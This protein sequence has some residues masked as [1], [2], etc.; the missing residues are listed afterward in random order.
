VIERICPECGGVVHGRPN[1]IFCSVLCRNS[2]DALKAR[3]NYKYRRSPERVIACKLCSTEVRTTSGNKAFCSRECRREFD[4]SNPKPKIARV[5]SVK[6]RKPLGFYVYGWVRPGDSL[7]YYIG[8][9]V[10]SRAWRRHK[11]GV[12]YSR[13]EK[14]KTPGTEVVIYRDR[15]TEEG[16]YLVESVLIDLFTSMG[17][18]LAND[19]S[20]LQ[21][22]EVPPL[23]VC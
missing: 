16:A 6:K 2:K 9:G 19:I 22:R 8:K 21:R 5:S 11:A 17:A 14:E 12:L 15:L 20:G 1:K 13:C 7:P 4:A 10:E 3:V 18:N 23:E